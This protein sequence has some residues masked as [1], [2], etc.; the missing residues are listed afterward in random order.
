MKTIIGTA[1]VTFFVGILFYHLG[2]IRGKQHG[3]DAAEQQ[4]YDEWQPQLKNLQEQAQA[5][6]DKS[7]RT[8]AL[9]DSILAEAIERQITTQTLLN[10]ARY[11]RDLYKKNH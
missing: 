8:Q 9:T 6:I 11:Y 2:F 3:F 7:Q 10:E 1:I 4:Y 5:N